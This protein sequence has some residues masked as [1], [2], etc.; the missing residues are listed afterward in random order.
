VTTIQPTCQTATGTIMIAK[1]AGMRYSIN[2]SAFDT[3]SV[4]ANLL[5]DIYSVRAMNSDSCISNDTTVTIHVQPA[6]PAAPKVTTIQPTCQ[7]ATG[8]I[9]IS[10]VA[11]LRYSINGSA[12]DTI[13]VYANLLPGNYSVRAMNADSCMSN[14]T[15]VTI[16]VQPATPKA[17][18]VKTIQPT[19]QVATGTITIAKVAGMSYSIN[20]SA[21]DTI[22]VYANLLPGNYS[23]RAMNS[24]SCISNDTTVTIHVQPAT[25]AVP[26]VTTIQPTCQVATGTIIIAKVTG[27]L[28]SINGTNYDTTGIYTN[29]ISGTYHVSAKNADGCISDTTIFINSQPITPT[30]PGVI[31]VQPSCQIQTG[32]IILK[33]VPGLRY[34]MNG[35]ESTDTVTIF[36]GLPPGQYVIQARSA[37]GC[38]SPDTTIN[39]KAIRNCALIA[40]N[41]SIVTLEDTPVTINVLANDYD[42]DGDPLNIT[43]VS[44]PA[45]GSVT[46]NFDNTV[47]YKPYPNYNGKDKFAYVITDGNSSDTASVLVT[48]IP[49]NDK[50]V[51]VNDTVSTPE[52]TPV[53]IPVLH[54]DYDVDG[55][56]LTVIKTTKPTNGTVIINSN[57]TV[58]YK[59]SANYHGN[60]QFDYIISDGE[61]TDTA[62]VF[63]TITSVNDRPIALD[64]SV[65]TPEEKPVT[66]NVLANDKDPEGD[67]LTIISIS[68][69][70]NGTVI[71][72]ADN[73]LT[74][75]PNV[76]YVGNDRFI[77]VISDGHST[78]TATVFITVIPVNDPPIAVNDT[79]Y[80]V[81]NTTLNINVL[82]NDKNP[83]GDQLSVSHNSK[84]GKGTA[85][86]K[87]DNSYDYTP[88][89]DY[90]GTDSFTY[91][92][93]DGHGGTSTATVFIYVLKKNHIPIAVNDTVRIEMNTEFKHD[94]SVNDIPSQDGGN[95]WSV[96]TPPKHGVIIQFDND[97]TYY[98]MPVEDFEGDD[99]FTYKITDVDGDDSLATVFIHIYW[100]IYVPEG[101]SPNGDGKNDRLVI[102]ELYKYPNNHI[103]IYNRWGNKVFEARNYQNDWNGETQFGVTIGGRKLPVGTYYYILDLGNG[104]VKK[105]FIYLNR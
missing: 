1:V 43:T 59:P 83:D 60:D 35:T 39:L 73:S 82:A 52:D 91:T 26:K 77:Y 51:A 50:P 72:N 55:D 24:D 69:P 105:S 21:F 68:K 12:F 34:S 104:R 20:G 63:I 28:Y 103:V 4:Y 2:G 81:E 32:T 94:V 27:I 31:A 86:L 41:D 19:C 85:D 53:I 15:T 23:V 70:A 30:T 89:P 3:I 78:D 95:R 84:P 10:K 7:T 48:V 64:D 87:G 14:D 6:T 33:K 62:T 57:N 61:L 65:S 46:K 47:T 90:R 45:H 99:S 75:T 37:A 96:V 66:I 58:T 8:T 38:V 18:Q 5:P 80:M 42:S 29:L 13:S 25:P 9:T 49:V 98:Y 56:V 16:H 67:P 100:D 102:K 76:D 71:Q 22:S 101:F 44:A 97:G 74:Y 11:G 88:E 40:N 54:N 36:R 93:S 17:P 79:V 92:I